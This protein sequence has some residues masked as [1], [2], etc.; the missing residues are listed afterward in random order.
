MDL[1]LHLLIGERLTDS[2][3]ALAEAYVREALRDEQRIDRITALSAFPA[4]GVM[5]TIAIE[6]KVL[7]QGDR[8]NWRLLCN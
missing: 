8:K 7:P 4:A 3:L 6:L 1:G 2:A 5:N